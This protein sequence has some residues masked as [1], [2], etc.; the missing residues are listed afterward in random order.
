ME[1]TSRD[2]LQKAGQEKLKKE[3]MNITQEM[4]E[5]YNAFTDKELLEFCITHKL[6]PE[7]NVQDKFDRESLLRLVKGL[8][9]GII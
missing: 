4:E 6:I 1:K 2:V 5:Y 8:K 7:N 3:W 9:N